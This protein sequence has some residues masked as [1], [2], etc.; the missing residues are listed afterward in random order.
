MKI[1]IVLACLASAALAC[2]AQ[3]GNLAD[4]KK[5]LIDK[6]DATAAR[7]LCADYTASKV[8]A[9]QVE[10]EKC[11]ANVEMFGADRIQINADKNGN[12]VL[13]DEYEPAAVDAALMHLN[14]GIQLA[15]QDLSI[16]QGRLHVLE[17]SR[18][19]KEMA[20][21]L[22]QSCTLYQGKEVP[23]AW[24]DYASELNDLHEFEFGLALMRVM[25]R[26]YPGNPDIIGNIG[27]FLSILKRDK[28]AIPYLEKSVQMAPADPINAW[29][30][31][32][33]Y[34]YAGQNEQAGEWYRKA[35]SLDTDADRKKHDFCL[36]A[37][38]IEKKLNDQP[39]ACGLQKEN[40]P[41]DARTACASSAASNPAP[42]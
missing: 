27:A 14:R 19:Y 39:R 3:T 16:H 1:P 32:R 28:E 31:A 37:E 33:A 38:F 5:L 13:H 11:L 26:H 4:W 22:E 42:K 6:K 12:A 21:A 17:I 18:R 41:N 36:Y 25:E 8:L 23:N 30:L 9:E 15:P 2:A 40:C 35:L 10:A 29:D 7:T 24:L 20:P 34:D